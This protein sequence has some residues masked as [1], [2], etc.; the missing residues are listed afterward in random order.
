[1]LPL[2]RSPWIGRS[3]QVVEGAEHP[4]DGSGVGVADRGSVPGD[5]EVRQDPPAGEELG[6]GLG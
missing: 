2:Q 4:L 6:P 3:H 5:L 1:M